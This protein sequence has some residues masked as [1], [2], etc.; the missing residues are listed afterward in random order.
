ME[1]AEKTEQRNRV[2]RR[3]RARRMRRVMRMAKQYLND[4]IDRQ[5]SYS[6][7][8][9]AGRYMVTYNYDVVPVEENIEKDPYEGED[10]VNI[11]HM[12]QDID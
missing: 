11:D 5:V 1:T 3:I 9:G 4:Y 12:E 6:K 7:M 8:R 10:L 2:I